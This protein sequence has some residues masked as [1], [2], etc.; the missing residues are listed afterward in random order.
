M[1]IEKMLLNELRNNA[2]IPAHFVLGARNPNP[3]IRKLQILTSSPFTTIDKK[4]EQIGE[5]YRYPKTSISSGKGLREMTRLYGGLLL[6]NNVLPIGDIWGEEHP[7]DKSLTR[8]NTYMVYVLAA[9]LCHRWETDRVVDFRLATEALVKIAICNDIEAKIWRPLIDTNKLTR[10]EAIIFLRN[11]PA[12]WRPKKLT[13]GSS[14]Q[15]IN[16]R[17]KTLNDLS[18]EIGLK[19]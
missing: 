14:L 16:S 2:H 15:I 6:I 8:G 9:D 3:L 17:L 18:K 5:C 4:V 12:P 1:E 10:D 7:D 19:T 11:E 13:L